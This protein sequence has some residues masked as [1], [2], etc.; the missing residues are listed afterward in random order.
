MDKALEK[1]ALFYNMR[2]RELEVKIGDLVLLGQFQGDKKVK[3]VGPFKVLELRNN[4]FVINFDSERMMVNLDQLRVYTLR[5]SGSDDSQFSCGFLQIPLS[6]E[7]SIP[8]SNRP[9]EKSQPHD[10]LRAKYS[11]CHFCK[12]T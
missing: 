11:E 10:M 2:S 7:S 3:F 1:K 4:N 9:I 6:N 8:Q 5:E 12:A